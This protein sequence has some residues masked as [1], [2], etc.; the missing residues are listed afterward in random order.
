MNV[1]ILHNILSRKEITTLKEKKN[2]NARIKNS[3]TQIL[4]NNLTMDVIKF[5]LKN[6]SSL[7]ISL[8]YS[9]I[10]TLFFPVNSSNS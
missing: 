5:K 8:C 10:L 4:S 6:L 2:Q 9:S 3:P 7:P 1:N